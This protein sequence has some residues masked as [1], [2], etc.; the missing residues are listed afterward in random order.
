MAVRCLVFILGL[1]LVHTVSAQSQDLK[2][3]D[4]VLTPNYAGTVTEV[5][6]KDQP[7]EQVRVESKEEIKTSAIYGS[8]EVEKVKKEKFSARERRLQKAQDSG[9]VFTGIAL[10]RIGLDVGIGPIRLGARAGGR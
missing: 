10:P 1:T 8:T 9:Y 5:I 3:G 2:V 7:N 6:N 4:E